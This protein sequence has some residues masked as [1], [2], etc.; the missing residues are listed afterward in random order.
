[1][2]LREQ[3]IRQET[4]DGKKSGG[5]PGQIYFSV[6]GACELGGR[7]G[8]QREVMKKQKIQKSDIQDH[9]NLRSSPPASSFLN[10]PQRCVAILGFKAKL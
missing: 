8:D 1:M 4:R 5:N 2:P 7:I 3:E 6:C 9:P 10:L